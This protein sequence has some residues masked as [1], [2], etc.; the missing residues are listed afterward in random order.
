[1][2]FSKIWVSFVCIVFPLVSAFELL[3]HIGFVGLVNFP[4]VVLAYEIVRNRVFCFVVCS[5]GL[6]LRVVSKGPRPG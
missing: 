2:N 5:N 1:M 3:E 4:R 6:G